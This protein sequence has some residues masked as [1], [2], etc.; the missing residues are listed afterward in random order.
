MER[1]LGIIKPDAVQAGKIGKIIQMIE[2]SGFTIREMRMERLTFEK[3]C[4]FYAVHK[5]KPF[6]ESLCRFMSSGPIVVMML[7]RENAI[8]AWRELMGPTNSRLAPPGTIRGC[9][10]TDIE[11]NAVHGSDSQET[12]KTEL[13]FFFGE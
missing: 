11:K 4:A 9:F 3:A 12:A 1:T 5:D 7:E 2:A 13:S 10:G 8:D 6:Y